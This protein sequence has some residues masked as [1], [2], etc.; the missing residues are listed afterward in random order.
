MLKS[1]KVIPI[2][3]VVLFI[4]LSSFGQTWQWTRMADLPFATSNNA[5]CEA[6]VNGNE[7]VYSFGGIDT[8]KIYSGIHQRSF[9][10]DVT[11][12]SWAEIDS[13]PD[14]TGKIAAGA[15][16]V[17]DKI[18]I[19]GGY[20]VLASS[21]E[22]SSN[23]VHVYNPVTDAFEADAASIPVPIDDHI[24]CVY[25]DSLIFI[26]TGWSNTGN[27]PNVQIFDPS[28]NQW[29]VGTSTAPNYLYTS[30]GASGTIIG[31]TLYY[32]GG[33]AGNSFSA[34]KYMRKGYIDP[35][36][37]TNITWTLMNDAPGLEGYRSACSSINDHAF[38]VGGSSVSY[39]YNGIAYNGSG[40]VDPSARILS[41]DNM[42]YTYND[43]SMQEYG[44][45]DLRGIA[46]FSNYNWFIAGGMDSAQVVT[47][48]TFRISLL[49]V[50]VEELSQSSIS[51]VYL[52]QL[53]EISTL[54]NEKA[55]LFDLAGRMI[56]EFE[57]NKL[58]KI[59]RE[60]FQ[61]GI[62]IFVQNERSIRIRL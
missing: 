11:L 39:N 60:N 58:F 26:V 7:Y 32:H 16:F 9:K 62:Y 19:I 38:W 1:I 48:R 61:S 15:S 55:Q 56:V 23:K 46:K 50:G 42:S 47:P 31:D 20:H 27:V 51:V 4:A 13:L 6:V 2:T 44:V 25:K 17:K 29:Q 49:N 5:L 34:R 14:A 24:Q 35:T 37:P 54:K 33:A 40:G 30:F 53:V 21:T 45:M 43:A 59:Q 36:D 12:D 3:V 22:I 52:D 18:Y 57:E 10:Y 28:L 41:F 8:S